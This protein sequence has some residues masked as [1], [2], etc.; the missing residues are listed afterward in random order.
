MEDNIEKL[1]PR[2]NPKLRKKKNRRNIPVSEPKLD[3][4]ELKYVSECVRSNWIS[5]VGAFIERFENAFKRCSDTRY[6]V[7]CSSGTAALHLALAALGIKNGDE[8]IIPAFT[9]I[10]TANAATY[11]GARPVLVDADPITWNMDTKKIESKITKFTKAIIPVHT[12][13]FPADMDRIISI[14]RK[15]NLFVVEDAAEAHGAEYKGKKA[16]SL[17]DVAC[18]SFYGNKIITTGEGG[19]VTTNSKNIAEKVRLLRDHAFS[20]ERHF[21][22]KYLGYNYRMTNLQAAIGLAQV[23]RF[24]ELVASRI[25]NARYYNLLLRNLGGIEFPPE[26]KG[27]KNVYWMYSI[28]INDDFGLTRDALREYLARKGIETRTFFIPIH[29]QPIYSKMYRERFPVA[30]ELCRK[31]M[32]LPSAATLTKKDIEYVVECI[33]SVQKKAI[34]K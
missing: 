24:K 20:S 4:N 5:S 28:L 7:A 6:A 14:T 3:G 13:G 18:F 8:V 27:I 29:L 17:G 30:E 22:H 25:R 33:K 34:R 11:L 12:Y 26:A 21:W 15:H 9:M 16:G 2:P 19:M 1:L 10:A 23:E 32:Y 31:G